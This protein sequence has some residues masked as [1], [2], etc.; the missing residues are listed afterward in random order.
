MRK[1]WTSQTIFGACAG[2]L[3][4]ALGLTFLLIGLQSYQTFTQ[5]HLPLGDYFLGT[6]FDGH[7]R[8]GIIPFAVGSLLLV[9]LSLL[10]AVPLSIGVALYLTEVAPPWIKAPLRGVVELFLGIPSVIFGLLGLVVLVPFFATLL[11]NLAQFFTGVPSV[12]GHAPIFYNGSGILP[13][14]VVISF[15]V[16]PTITTIS[17][18]ALTAVPRELREGSLAL[19]ATRWQTLSKT[20]IPAA[21]PGIMTGVILGATRALGETLAV[22]FVIGNSGTFPV[23]F[24][25]VYPYIEIGNTGVLTTTLLSFPDSVHGEKLYN[26]VWTTAFILLIISALTVAASRAVASRRIYA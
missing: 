11:N 17:V 5:S 9:I 1:E 24:L 15:M 8:F 4:V 7:T 14:V 3:V 23:R 2:I 18:D 16:M 26:V 21:L 6:S 13:A 20:I 10:I 12:N 19:G 22:A 25:N